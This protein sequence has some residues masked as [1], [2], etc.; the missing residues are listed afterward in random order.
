M[1]KST[2]DVLVYSFDMPALLE[3]LRKQSETNRVAS[4]FNIDI[5]KY[6]VI[7]EE[8][9]MWGMYGVCVCAVKAYH[10]NS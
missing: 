6:Q 9:E 8:V 7:V 5:L 4:Y 3:H 2:A 1:L 10:S